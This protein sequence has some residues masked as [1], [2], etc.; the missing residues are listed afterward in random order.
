MRKIYTL[1]GIRHCAIRVASC[2]GKTV[3]FYE[4]KPVKQ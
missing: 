3:K 4:H 1:C 2:D